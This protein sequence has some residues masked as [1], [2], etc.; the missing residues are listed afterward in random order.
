MLILAHLLTSNRGWH[1]TTIR[2]LRLTDPEHR[3]E[4][5]QEL[6]QLAYDSRI[7]A[8]HLVLSQ[9]AD[10]ETAFRAYSSHASLIFLGFIP[11]HPDE[12]RSFYDRIS[13]QLAGMPATFLAASAGDTDLD[14]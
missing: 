14:S 4:A 12:C 2:L 1:K 7:E 6:A 9:E 3:P 5:E 8:Q 13:V 10:F 11:P